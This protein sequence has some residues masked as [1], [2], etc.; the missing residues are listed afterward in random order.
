MGEV[1]GHI[2]EHVNV[3]HNVNSILYMISNI[4]PRARDVLLEFISVFCDENVALF[5]VTGIHSI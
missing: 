5:T 2:S 4:Y 3:F 1:S